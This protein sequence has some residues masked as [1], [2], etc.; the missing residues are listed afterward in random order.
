MENKTAKE[1]AEVS[2]KLRVVFEKVQD[3]TH[4]K[5]PIDAFIDAKDFE[6]TDSAIQFFTGTRIHSAV[7]VKSGTNNGKYHIKADGYFLGPCN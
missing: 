3:K 1:A 5:N 4:W 2:A 7:L 6:V